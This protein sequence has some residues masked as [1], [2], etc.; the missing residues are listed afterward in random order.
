MEM[1]DEK[2]R[3]LCQIFVD[4]EKAFDRD[5]RKGKEWALR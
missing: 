1:Y 4:L 3:R 5:P 2:K